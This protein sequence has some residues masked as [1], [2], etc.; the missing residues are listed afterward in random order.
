MQNSMTQACLPGDLC[1]PMLSVCEHVPAQGAPCAVGP[2]LPSLLSDFAL[3]P[4]L[5]DSWLTT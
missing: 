2:W 1:L 5:A 4:Y 3:A